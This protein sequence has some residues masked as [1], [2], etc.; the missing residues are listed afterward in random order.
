MILASV[1]IALGAIISIANLRG[2]SKNL[3]LKETLHK[4]SQPQLKPATWLIKYKA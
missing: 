4:S 1:F 3:M 2:L